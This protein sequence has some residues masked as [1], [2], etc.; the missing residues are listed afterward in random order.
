M[1]CSLLVF[2]PT[3]GTQKAA[4][5]LCSELGGTVQTSDLSDTAFEGKVF[6]PDSN[7][8]AVI[9]VPSFGGRVPAIAAER[10]ITVNGGGMNCVVLCV[11]GNRA[12]DDTLVELVDLAKGCHFQVIAAVAAVAQHSIMP[13]YA[14]DRPDQK[15]EANLREIA[16]KIAAKLQSG[17][18]GDFEVPG[19]RPYQK[20][21]GAG[22]VPKAGAGC[23]ACGLCAKACPTGAIDRED[24]K[25]TDR[26]KCISCMRCVAKCPHKARTVSSVM[27]RA[28]ALT[29]KKACSVRKECE[30]YL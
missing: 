24:P 29:I 3:G 8:I 20:A 27:V 5:I 2:S 16:Q 26:K 25:K 12:Y 17:A 1:N 22:L 21:G 13:Q 15:D 7:G 6:S 4:N 9:A 14:T 11:Y 30:L 19:N 10:L 23:V 18:R 28:A